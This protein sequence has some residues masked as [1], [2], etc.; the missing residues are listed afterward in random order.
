MYV[1]EVACGVDLVMRMKHNDD[2]Q[3]SWVMFDHVK[4]VEGWTTM[5]C[6]VYDAT[7][8]KL[9]IIAI[10]SMQWEDTNVL[11]VL[12]RKLH[13]IMFKNYSVKG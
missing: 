3:N 1:H 5:A 10:C 11:C 2:L 12:R 4:C 8:C 6:H 7:H 9:L 13:D